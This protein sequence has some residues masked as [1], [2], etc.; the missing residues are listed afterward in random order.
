MRTL[1]EDHVCTGCHCAGTRRPSVH[2]IQV[3]AVGGGRKD[4]GGYILKGT[5]T[6]GCT[7]TTESN[8]ETDTFANGQREG[9]LYASDENLH[10]SRGT[11]Q[12]WIQTLGLYTR[13]FYDRKA[14]E[15]K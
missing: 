5:S 1:Q 15:T 6:W 10:F 3:S 12:I 7:A 4:L 13:Y 14:M 8:G 9:I 11:E 2:W